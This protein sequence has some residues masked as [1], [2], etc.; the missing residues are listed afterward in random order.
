[1]HAEFGS[2][3]AYPV[4]DSTGNRSAL[5]LSTCS[6]RL[7][8][9]CYPEKHLTG[10]RK[11]GCCIKS[12]SLLSPLTLSLDVSRVQRGPCV[13][14]EAQENSAA[15]CQKGMQGASLTGPSRTR[16]LWMMICSYRVWRPRTGAARPKE[17]GGME[18][19]SVQASGPYL[20]PRYACS[21]SGMCSGT[22]LKHSG[23]LQTLAKC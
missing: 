9:V 4:P 10:P 2:T 3:V 17:A 1:M 11:K 6:E 15:S 20:A 23:I 16:M 12:Q 19:L 14:F 22:S 7:L 13:P 21:A 18:I 8:N 5:A